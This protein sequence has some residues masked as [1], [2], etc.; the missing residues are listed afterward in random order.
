MHV[1]WRW[2][3]QVIPYIFAQGG[4]IDAIGKTIK[5]GL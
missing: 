3:K 1:D 5:V 2:V 4:L